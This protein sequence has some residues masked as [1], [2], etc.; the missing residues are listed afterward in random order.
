MKSDPVWVRPI[1]PVRYDVAIDMAS[2]R[3]FGTKRWFVAQFATSNGWLVTQAYTVEC[4]T[5]RIRLD[6]GE[7]SNL[8]TKGAMVR[9]EAYVPLRPNT[10][11]RT[12]VD[13][14]CA[15]QAAQ[16]AADAVRAVHQNM[17]PAGIP[18]DFEHVQFEI[19][20]S[21]GN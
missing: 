16:L 14:A 6:W 21:A 4:D 18:T 1:V 13:F 7:T 3:Q 8:Q 5:D 11:L 12:I 17:D 19:G 9:E 10:P 20:Y 2:F 15:A